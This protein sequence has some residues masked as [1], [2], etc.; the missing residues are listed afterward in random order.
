MKRFGNGAMSL[1]QAIS[2]KAA[3]TGGRVAGAGLVLGALI[4][5]VPTVLVP[6]PARAAAEHKLVGITI[7]SSV[8][9]VLAEYGD[10]TEILTGADVLNGPTFL[11]TLGAST[12]GTTSL[13]PS[14]QVGATG[15]T[16]P[17]GMPGAM[18]GGYP[19]AGAGRQPG[20]MGQ[21]GPGGPMGQFGPNGPMSRMGMGAA[22]A[23]S[24]DATGGDTTVAPDDALYVY[25]KPNGVILEFLAT[26][27]GRVIQI[28]VLGY[29]GSAKTERGITLGSS[30]STVIDK[31]GYPESLDASNGVT[32]M[33]YLDKQH[34]S[35]Q[36]HENK[37]V[38]ITVAAVE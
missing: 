20:S 23:A 16:A 29:K 10:P 6:M 2:L 18:A 22:G 38:G 19:G 14:G 8:K 9:T 34:V 7:F 27:D 25:Q 12:S 21:F 31:Y 15:A 3:K 5:I 32:T 13:G 37:V 17:M 26:A 1:M 4:L 11:T 28:E 36:L 35:F 33:K 24:S 30:Y